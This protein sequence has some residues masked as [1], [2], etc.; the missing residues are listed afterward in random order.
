M[1]KTFLLKTMFLLCA[2]VTWGNAWGDTSTL[3]F[4]AACGG[5]GTADDGANWTV[6]SDGTESTF[7]N[8][9]GIHYGTSSAQVSYIQLSTSD[10]QG[11]ITKVVVNASAASGV[12]AAV[13]VTVGGNAFGGAAQSVS[14]SAS[15]YTFNGS[16]S[17]AVVVRLAKPSKAAK[18]IYVKSVVVTY[19]SSGENTSVTIDASGITNTDIALGT[20]AGSLSAVVKNSSAVAIDGATVTWS[21]SKPAV[22]TINESTGVVTLVKRGST[23]ITASYAGVDG[24]YKSS[25]NTYVLNV[26]NSSAG[27]GTALNPFT[28]TEAIDAIEASEIETET[29]YYVS[30]IVSKV[31]AINSGAITYWISDDGTTNSQLECYKGKGIDGANFDAITDVEV[32]DRVVVKGKLTKYNTIYEFSQNNE[33]VSISKPL[34]VNISTFTATTT[35][36]LVGETTNTSVTN[37]VPAWTPTSYTYESSDTDVATVD[38]DGKITAV[39]KGTATIT[40]TPNIPISNAIYK[41]GTSK[42]IDITVSNPTHTAKFSVNGTIDDNDNSVVEE[43]EAVTFPVNP[44]N[45]GGKVFMGWTTASIDG[46]QNAAPSTL[47][48][49]ATMGNTDVIYY[50]VFANEVIGE[51]NVSLEITPNTVNIPTGYG[52]SNKFTEYTLEGKKF[53]VQQ[54]Y[55]NGTKLQWRAEGNSNGTGTMYNTEPLNKIQS[56]VLKYDASDSNKNFSVKVGTTENP[57]SGTVITP[58]SSANIYTFDCSDGEYNYF[59]MANGIGAGYLTSVEITY[60]GSTTVYTDYCTTIPA[61]AP[62]SIS[63]AGWAT[64]CSEYALD[65]TGVTELTAYTASKEGAVVKFNKVTGKVPAN[66]GLLV[67]GTTSDVP[68]TT[69]ASAVENVLKGVTTETVKAAGAVF[70]L[71]QGANG[72]GFYKNTSAFTLRA[73]SAYLDASD[74]ATARVFIALEDEATGIENLIPTLSKGEG[75]V[76]DLSGRRVA[77]PAK[78]LYIVNGKKVVVK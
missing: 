23:T 5:S 18:A 65:F 17:G 77:K 3:N 76:L 41:P 50:A 8:T 72:L 67:S 31:D 39:A 48:T 69:G 28:P 73:N 64:Y 14:S 4:T 29:E 44:A 27:E 59:V 36:L 38:E 74:V 52:D 34:P 1:K 54:M 46:S 37:E 15:N 43:G 12:T 60:K 70:V 26:T 16:A 21:S 6:T 19:A 45:L 10:I 57:T 55:K 24:T 63:A 53:K 61:T 32:R 40:V 62:V 58:M 75:V 13:S 78:G 68:V 42:T 9:K 71:K 30:G 7:D 56:I 11:T 47:V 22:A 33:L 2:L 51:G 66:T 35:A 20:A 49:S 25:S